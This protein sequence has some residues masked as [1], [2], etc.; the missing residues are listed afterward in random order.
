MFLLLFLSLLFSQCKNNIRSVR[1]FKSVFFIILESPVNHNQYTEEKWKIINDLYDDT[2]MP[3][4]SSGQT[5]LTGTT[6]AIT[7]DPL[8]ISSINSLTLTSDNDDPITPNASC[9][10]Q[11]KATYKTDLGRKRKRHIN[12]WADVRRKL[13]TNSGK[14]YVSRRGKTI[15]AKSLKPPCPQTCKLKCSGYF[16]EDIRKNIFHEFWQLSDHTKQWEYI[17]KF[18]KII[19]KRRITTEGPSRRK[20][21]KKYYLPLPANDTIYKAKQVCLK[22][23]CAT[24]A[25]TDRTIRTAHEKLDACGITRSDNRGKHLNHPKKI[26]EELL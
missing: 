16:T 24:L 9:M 8:N 17:N 14:E 1:Y 22:I 2:P 26:A 6:P 23:F 5:I 19:N 25:I 21:T 4:P 15:R 12:E 18:T 7:D 11:R 13:L 3:S 20:F 10:R